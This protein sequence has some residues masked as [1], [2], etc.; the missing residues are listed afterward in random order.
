MAEQ[1][2]CIMHHD[3]FCIKIKTLEANEICVQTVKICFEKDA[4]KYIT[5][6]YLDYLF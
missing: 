5:M 3:K 6:H 1:I 2:C 4:L